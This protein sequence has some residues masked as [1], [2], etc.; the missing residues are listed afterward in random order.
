MDKNRGVRGINISGKL[1]INII[2]QRSPCFWLVQPAKAN[3]ANAE[4]TGDGGD[5]GDGTII[6]LVVWNTKLYFFRNSREID[7]IP[8]DE[9]KLFRGL[10]PPTR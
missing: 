7:F 4:A 9:L 2:N 6:W 3:E 8:T 5:G 1:H 10:R